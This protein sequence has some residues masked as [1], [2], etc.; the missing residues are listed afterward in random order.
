M[1]PQPIAID[2]LVSYVGWNLA[3]SLRTLSSSKSQVQTKEVIRIASSTVG[4][5]GATV[6]DNQN[7]VYVLLEERRHQ[8][9]QYW[10]PF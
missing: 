3:R 4:S 5:G 7:F 10:L 9:R 1:S 8:S 6:A 2:K